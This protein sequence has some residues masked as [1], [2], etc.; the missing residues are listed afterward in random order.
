[1][2]EKKRLNKKGQVTIF[3]IIA[4]LII[5]LAI[6][7]Y[8]YYPKIIASLSTET[9][10][11]SA[12]MQE[13]I[14]EQ[15]EDNVQIISLQGG[16]YE[17]NENS[18]YFY[19][20]EDES[21]G[22]YVKYLCYTSKDLQKCISQEPFLTEHVE[23]EILNSISTDVDDCFNSMVKSYD[24]KGYEV[25]LK[26]GTAEVSIIPNLISTNLN[27]TL[28]LTK[29]DETETYRNFNVDLNS[30]L[31]DILEVAKNILIW[32]MNVGDSLP[33]AYMYNNPYLRVEKHRKGDDTKIYVLTDINTE[34]SFRFAVRSI[35]YSPGIG[36][37]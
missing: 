34:E 13:C 14:Q 12:Y 16:N 11:P 8:L 20:K 24:N 5:A 4:V 32:E 6:L 1:M 27:S 28:T 36:V 37:I 2:G 9:K 18:G 30:N 35:A 21:E 25:N 10:N 31:Y 22:K 15:I 17:V 7:I 33:E 19:K 3:I 23:A 26:R 29:S